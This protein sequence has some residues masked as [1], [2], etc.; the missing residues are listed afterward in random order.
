MT[1]ENDR[2]LL[3]TERKLRLVENQIAGARARPASPENDESMASLTSM[4][5]QL[6]EEIIRYRSRQKRQA[7]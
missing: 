1:L 5:N 3:N 6:R 4:A 2:Q 7:S